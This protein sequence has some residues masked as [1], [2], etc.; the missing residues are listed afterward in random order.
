MSSPSLHAA[1]TPLPPRVLVR[2]PAERTAHDG[3]GGPRILVV[4][5]DYIVAL[6][7]EHELV[8]AGFEVVGLVAAADEAVAKAAEERPDLAVVDIRLRGPRDGVDA[9]LELRERY[10]VPSLFASAHGDPHTRERAQAAMP[11]GWIQKP[12]SADA[13]IAMI[14]QVL[15]TPR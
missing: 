4:E 2:A 15:G 10:G 12:Y 5:D 13:L 1:A 9:A 11:L 14:R 6:N 3:A 8:A 7:L